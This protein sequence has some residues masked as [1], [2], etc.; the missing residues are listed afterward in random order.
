M[1]LWFELS[2]TIWMTLDTN[3]QIE[4]QLNNFSGEGG[5]GWGMTCHIFSLVKNQGDNDASEQ[6]ECTWKIYT[7]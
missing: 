4:I 3:P 2:Y 7:L 1:N 6:T 5:G